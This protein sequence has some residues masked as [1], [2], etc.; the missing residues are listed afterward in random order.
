[1]AV[2]EWLRPD[3]RVLACHVHHSG[4]LAATSIEGRQPVMRV[5]LKSLL[6]AHW[7]I[8]GISKIKPKAKIPLALKRGWRR[9]R[10]SSSD[11]HDAHPTPRGHGHEQGLPKSLHRDAPRFVGAGTCRRGSRLQPRCASDS[12]RQMFLL[13]RAGCAT[14]EGGVAFGYAGGRLRKDCQWSRRGHAG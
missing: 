8:G 10:A 5:C 14:T 6:R 9:C 7:P 4:A 2:I 13:S 3:S 11:C 1:M 12:F